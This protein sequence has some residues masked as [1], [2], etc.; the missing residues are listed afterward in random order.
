MRIETLA[1]RRING[2]SISE[3]ARAFGVASFPEAQW[4]TANGSLRSI[5]GSHDLPL[6]FEL[7]FQCYRNDERGNAE[8]T[9]SNDLDS[10]NDEA[11]LPRQLTRW[12]R[13]MPVSILVLF[14]PSTI[15]FCYRDRSTWL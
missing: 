4:R 12:E 8:F 14:L 9:Y 11:R 2:R 10:G 7:I 5:A 3:V 15:F 13:K 1:S 6:N